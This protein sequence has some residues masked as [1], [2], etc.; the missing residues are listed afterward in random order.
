M[1]PNH[2]R[3]ITDRLGHKLLPSDDV[4]RHLHFQRLLDSDLFPGTFENLMAQF[5]DRLLDHQPKPLLV[6]LENGQVKGFS[7]EQT[8]ILKQ[9]VGFE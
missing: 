6:Q 4:P 2:T 7:G 3:Q 5:L 9:R 1:T 8:H